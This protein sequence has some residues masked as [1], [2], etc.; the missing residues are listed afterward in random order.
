MRLIDI[1]TQKMKRTYL[2]RRHLIPLA[3]A[4]LLIPNPDES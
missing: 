2:A 3:I 1:K 4:L